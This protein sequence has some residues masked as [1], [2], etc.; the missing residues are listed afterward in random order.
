VD[1]DGRLGEIAVMFNAHIGRNYEPEV[2]RP[3]IG[4]RLPYLETAMA[5]IIGEVGSLDTYLTETLGV[6]GAQQDAI[7][8][9][10]L[11]G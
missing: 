5:T 8:E 1:V 9:K 7:R 2:Y 10:L 6:S 11:E 3:F 4:V